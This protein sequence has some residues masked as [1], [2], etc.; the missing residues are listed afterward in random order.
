M[1][2]KILICHWKLQGQIIYFWPFSGQ[3]VFSIKMFW[4]PMIRLC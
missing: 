2:R 4:K 1:T 3:D